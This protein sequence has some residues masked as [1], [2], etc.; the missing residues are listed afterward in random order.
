MRTQMM[1]KRLQ[2]YSYIC[3]VVVIKG[4]LFFEILM[5]QTSENP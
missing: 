3:N 1:L 2:H 5:F 4:G